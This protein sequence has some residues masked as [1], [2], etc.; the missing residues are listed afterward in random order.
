MSNC[1][2]KHKALDLCMRIG[3]GACSFL[4]ALV[5]GSSAGDGG[6][7]ESVSSNLDKPND[8]PSNAP[9]VLKPRDHAGGGTL[10]RGKRDTGISCV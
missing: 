1:L 5:L 6:A 8:D 2:V 7:F 9:A 4:G 10:R 3:S